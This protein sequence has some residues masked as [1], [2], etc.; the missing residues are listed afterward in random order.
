MSEKRQEQL[1]LFLCPGPI[2]RL[3]ELVTR[4]LAVDAQVHI[5]SKVFTWTMFVWTCIHWRSSDYLSSVIA[6][7]RLHN[8]S[9]NLTKVSQVVAH[10]TVHDFWRYGSPVECSMAAFVVEIEPPPQLAGYTSARTQRWKLDHGQSPASPSWD[11]IAK[12][13]PS[14]GK[15]GPPQNQYDYTTLV[16]IKLLARIIHE[17]ILNSRKQSG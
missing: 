4:V 13:T 8:K 2:D 11:C 17:A 5:G 14:A 15:Y 1:S 3:N 16:K 6:I 7:G 9:A 12:F 10:A